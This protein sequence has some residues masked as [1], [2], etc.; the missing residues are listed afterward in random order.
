MWP[1]WRG[2]QGAASAAVHAFRWLAATISSLDPTL[3]VKERPLQRM[4]A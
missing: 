4:T 1:R 3:R 2:L